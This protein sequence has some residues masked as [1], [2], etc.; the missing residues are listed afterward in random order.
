[1]EERRSIWSLIAVPAV[2]TL[3]IT[4]LRLAGE[5]AHWPAPWFSNEAGGGAAIVGIS[6]LPIFFGPWF[7]LKLKKSGQGA[8]SAGKAIGF[9]CLAIVVLAGGGAWLNSALHHISPMILLPFGVLLISAFIPGI[10]WKALGKTLLA[11]AFAA[12]L[13]VLLVYFLAMTGNGGKGWGTHYDAVPAG[14]PHVGLAA[15]FLYL[16]LLPQMTLWIAWTVCGGALFG[17]IAGALAG[18]KKAEA[19]AAA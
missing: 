6:W 19:P 11:Y 18:R 4:I 17:T 7:A 5:L 10:G 1:M 3:A 2:I 9:A 13:P 8:D 12:R 14:F 15:K 16:G